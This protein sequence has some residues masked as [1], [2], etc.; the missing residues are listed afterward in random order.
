MEIAKSSAVAYSHL[1]IDDAITMLYFKNSDEFFSFCKEIGWE[2][3]LI[4]KKVVF[5]KNQN[6]QSEI[7][8]DQVIHNVLD[9]AQE[10]ERIV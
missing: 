5:R 9:Y 4:T 1:P 10:L 7:P 8:V 2:V 3:D 6:E